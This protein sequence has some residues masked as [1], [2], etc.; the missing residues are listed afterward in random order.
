MIFDS[1]AKEQDA[2]VVLR[3]ASS[4]GK[5]GDFTVSAIKRTRLEIDFETGTTEAGTITPPG[6]RF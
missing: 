4:D 3:N 5:L 6:S 1:K 2:I